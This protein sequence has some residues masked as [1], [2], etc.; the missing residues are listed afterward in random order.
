MLEDPAICSTT[1]RY[2]IVTKQF[3]IKATFSVFENIF[4]NFFQKLFLTRHEVKKYF[5]ALLRLLSWFCDQFT[6]TN[7]HSKIAL[8]FHSL[9]SML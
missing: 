7:L 8:R 2:I 3:N 1:Q 4:K 6:R 9:A 5:S